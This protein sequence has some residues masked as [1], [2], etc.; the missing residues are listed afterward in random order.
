MEPQNQAEI[1]PQSEI[2]T[3]E[4][5]NLSKSNQEK[6]SLLNDVSGHI[7]GS[8]YLFVYF[9]KLQYLYKHYSLYIISPPGGV[10]L[11]TFKG[12]TTMK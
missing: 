3:Q 1:L 10:L 11:K 2:V 8:I 4:P 6:Q 9:L 5:L 7:P 12:D